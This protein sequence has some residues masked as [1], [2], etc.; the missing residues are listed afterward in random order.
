[1]G[2][3]GVYTTKPTRQVI[4]E[5]VTFNDDNGNSGRVLAAATKGGVTYMAWERVYGPNAGTHSNKKFVMGLVILHSRGNGEVVYKE[6]SEDMGPCEAECPAR[7]LDLL[8]PVEEF[9]CGSGIEW[10]TGWRAKCRK[11]LD[12]RAKAPGDGAKIKF[13]RAIK[14]VDGTTHDTFTIHKRGRKVR[15]APEGS[16]Y[17]FYSI[18]NW[19]QFD[20]EILS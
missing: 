15:F 3:T 19:Q 2:S 12:K 1:M 13:A 4:T 20:F 5:A 9:A 18:S 16:T 10:A 6:V 11:A 7:I 17:A 8:S 14:F